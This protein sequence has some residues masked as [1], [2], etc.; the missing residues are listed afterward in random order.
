MVNHC[1]D[2]G[3]RGDKNRS[4]ETRRP[5]MPTPD[6]YRRYAAICAQLADEMQDKNE[7]AILVSISHQFRRL[8]NRQQKRLLATASAEKRGSGDGEEAD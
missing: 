7:R 1:A 3:A 6:E 4:G 5:V 8:A 2:G